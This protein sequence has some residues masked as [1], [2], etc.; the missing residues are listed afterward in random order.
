M[1]CKDHINTKSHGDAHFWVGV[2]SVGSFFNVWTVAAAP[3]LI[4]RAAEASNRTKKM[5]QKKKKTAFY[6]K[7]SFYF[8]L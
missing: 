1:F 2:M 4:G 5:W 7:V 6:Q 3:L 8:G